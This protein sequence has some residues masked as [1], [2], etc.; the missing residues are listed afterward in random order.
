MKNILGKTENLTLYNKEGKRVY[1]FTTRSNGYSIEYTRDSK[2]NELT[3]KSPNGFSSERTYDSK[4][5]ELTYKNSNGYSC[6]YAYDENGNEL[7]FKNSAG[8]SIGFDI[9]EFT[10]EELVSKLG[11]FKL[12]K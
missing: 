3:Y 6:E 8:E 1:E 9:P 7:T 10:M 5:N 12:K 4:G 2:G 11:N